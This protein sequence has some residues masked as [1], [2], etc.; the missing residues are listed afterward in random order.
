MNTIRSTWYG[1]GTLIV[2]GG[3]AYYFAKRSINAE[4]KARH[5]ADMKRRRITQSINE[6]SAP[7]PAPKQ[8]HRKADHAASPS[9]EASHDPAPISHSPD[10]GKTKPEEQSKFEATVPYRSRKGDRFS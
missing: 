7:K 8:R 2:A 3:G 1:W 4:K 5:E 6:S 10:N 9:T